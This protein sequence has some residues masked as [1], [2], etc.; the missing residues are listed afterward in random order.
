MEDTLVCWK[1]HMKRQVFNPGLIKTCPTC[2][3]NMVSKVLRDQMEAHQE[4]DRNTLSQSRT[5]VCDIYQRTVAMNEDIICALQNMTDAFCALEQIGEIMGRSL[6]NGLRTEYRQLKQEERNLT[7]V[8]NIIT[9]MP[10]EPGYVSF[11]LKEAHQLLERSR[12]SLGSIRRASKK[13][14]NKL[15]SRNQRTQIA[16]IGPYIRQ[17]KIKLKHARRY[18]TVKSHGSEGKQRQLN[19]LC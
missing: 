11:H 13:L 8:Y 9:Q 1:N 6:R 3:S 17:A 7:K 15:R 16:I 5:E 19:L 4:V 18:I 12:D 14:Y 10:V 2:N